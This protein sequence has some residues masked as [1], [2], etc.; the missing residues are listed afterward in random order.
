MADAD[1]LFA[2]YDVQKFTIKYTRQNKADV[3]LAS[4]SRSFDE[5]ELEVRNTFV[6]FWRVLACL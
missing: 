4:N 2:W 3:V 6:L 1:L 5:C